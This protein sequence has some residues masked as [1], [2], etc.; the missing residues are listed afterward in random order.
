[1]AVEKLVMSHGWAW[2]H[3][4]LGTGAARPRSVMLI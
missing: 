2:V 3:A 4:Y 1:L